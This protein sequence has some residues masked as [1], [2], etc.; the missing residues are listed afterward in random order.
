[1]IVLFVVFWRCIA[2]T[3][4]ADSIS[5]SPSL[6]IIHVLDRSTWAMCRPTASASNTRNTLGTSQSHRAI[7]INWL[8]KTQPEP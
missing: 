6:H 8:S 4:S 5:P 1:M 7:A 2:S 3:H